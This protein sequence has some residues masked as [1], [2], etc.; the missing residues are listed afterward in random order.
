MK[1]GRVD[2]QKLVGGFLGNLDSGGAIGKAAGSLKSNGL[3]GGLVGGA[4]AGG[5]VAALVSSKKVRKVGGKVLTYGGLAVLGGLAY[6]AWSDHKAGKAMTPA[7]A[8]PQQVPAAPEGSRFDPAAITDQSGNDFRLT[9]LRAMISA[10]LADGHVDQKEHQVIR[11][12]INAAGLDADEKSFLFDEL[13]KPADPIAI[14]SLTAGEEQAAEVY[15]A[16]LVVLDDTV[17]ED[18][19]YRERLGDALRLP[20]D[21]R[22]RLELHARE[23]L[24]G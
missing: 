22:Q 1:D 3:P 7:P 6:K 5:L 8:D 9:L 23:A 20:A 19:R 13:S 12:Q 24:Q 21:L 15:L 14:A 11:E 18:N 4:A 17:P 10:A 2:I 16:S